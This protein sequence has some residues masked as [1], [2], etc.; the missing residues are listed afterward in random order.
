[1]L[2]HCNCWRAWL[3]PV[4]DGGW[5]EKARCAHCSAWLEIFSQHY[6]TELKIVRR[7]LFGRIIAFDI[8]LLGWYRPATLGEPNGLTT[9]WR[10]PGMRAGAFVSIVAA[11]AAPLMGLPTATDG[12]IADR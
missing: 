11:V 5:I 3:R 10:R 6:F 1:M 12:V 7:I 4:V 2:L 8:I 9:P